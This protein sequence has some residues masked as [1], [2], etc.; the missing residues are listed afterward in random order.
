MTCKW[1]NN[2][3]F[4]LPMQRF[5]CTCVAFIWFETAN[6]NRKKRGVSQK[7]E[8]QNF[9]FET[10]RHVN[11]GHFI[12]K[13]RSFIILIWFSYFIIES[14]KENWVTKMDYKRVIGYRLILPNISYSSCFVPP[15]GSPN[16]ERIT[17]IH[18]HYSTRYPRSYDYM[19]RGHPKI[20]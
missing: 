3:L 19:L 8:H 15:K 11:Q 17:N 12:S 9:Q 1:F 18:Q 2:Y 10:S 5:S 7:N 6:Q 14:L 4:K 20:T 16:L 13:S